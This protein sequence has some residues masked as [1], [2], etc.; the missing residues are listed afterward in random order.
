MIYV[1]LLANTGIGNEVLK[2]LLS[3]PYVIV[4]SVLTRRF[5][6]DYPFYHTKEL[7]QE[8]ESNGILCFTNKDVNTDYYDY[9]KNRKIDVILVATFNQIIKNDI[10]NLPNV[11]I[12]N[13]HPSLLPKYRGPSPISWMILNGERKA[14]ITIHLL[15]NEI[16]AGDIILQ[17]EIDIEEKEILGSLLFKLSKLSSKMTCEFFD[18]YYNNNIELRQQDASESTYFKR[19]LKEREFSN[20]DSFSYIEKRL[21]A[22]HPFPGSIL[23]DDNREKFIVK[24]FKISNEKL[25]SKNFNKSLIKDGLNIM[26]NVES[27]PK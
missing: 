12:V 20:S 27:A 4:D 13:Y 15:T 18:L 5:E 22:F 10:L 7:Y 24:D 14:G 11:L 25:R 8:A 3:I 16:D 23:I 1:S 9:I 2:S 26:L 19:P 21:R 17:Q 6:S